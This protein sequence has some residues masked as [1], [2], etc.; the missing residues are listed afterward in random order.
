V[1]KVTEFYIW[2][3]FCPAP[4]GA[5]R[6]IATD[7]HCFFHRVL[8][9]QSLATDQSSTA[10]ETPL[11]PDLHSAY[12]PG[13]FGSL[14]AL[15]GRSM[16][17]RGLP[18]ALPAYDPW[19]TLARFCQK[20]WGHRRHQSSQCPG[21]HHQEVKLTVQSR[22]ETWRSYSGS[23]CTVR[24]SRWLEPVPASTPT[25]ADAQAVR[26]TRGYSRSA[27]VPLQHQ[28]WMVQCLP[29]W[30]FQVD[31]TDLSCCLRDPMMMIMLL[32]RLTV[33]EWLKTAVLNAQH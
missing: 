26:A 13:R 11:I 7:R 33:G 20:Y 23:S 12:S 5:N 28:H 27:T 18:Y 17:A 6:Y 30:T 10:D 21:H 24:D 15:A 9:E 25:G 22:D 32:T 4:V 19:N 3:L 29:S 2:A 31:A 1:E 14:E 16:E 8:Y